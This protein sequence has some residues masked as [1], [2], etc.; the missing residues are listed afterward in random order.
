VNASLLLASALMICA[1]AVGTRI[2]FAMPLEPRANW[3]FRILP[4][5]AMPRC[6]PAIRRSLYTIALAPVWLLA[7]ALLFWLWPWR[8]AAG[9]LAIL[10]LIGIIV[11]ELFLAGFR[12]IPFTCSYQP[13]KSRFNMAGLLFLIFLFLGFRVASWEASALAKPALYAITAGVFA[14]FAV[15]ARYRTNVQARTE[16]AALQFDDPPEPAIL[17]LGLYRDGVLPIEPMVGG[18]P[19][20]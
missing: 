11:A 6:L 9:H 15:L 17:S 1:S 7:A 18:P 12:K 16:G 13:G 5:P 8:I 14:L 19:A 2:V 10:A 4:L 3:L 20:A